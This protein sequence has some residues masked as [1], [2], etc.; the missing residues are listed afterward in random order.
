MA[1]LKIGTITHFYPK[2]GV[3]VVK[4][5]ANLAVGDKISVKGK[6][7]FSQDVASIQIEHESIKTAKKGQIVGLKVDQTANPGDEILREY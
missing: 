6:N 1:K 7:T 4:L 2:I 5:S 3:A